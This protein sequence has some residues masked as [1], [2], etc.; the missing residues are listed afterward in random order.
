MTDSSPSRNTVFLSI[1]AVVGAWLLTTFW[2]WRGYIGVDDIVYAKYAFEFHRLPIN[3]W[4]FRMPTIMAI[5]ASFALLG[6]TEFAAALPTVLASLGLSAGVALVCGWPR[7][8]NWKTNGAMLLVATMPLDSDMR[9]IPGASYLTGAF[10]GLGTAL[11]LQQSPAMR[12][13]GGLILAIC[14]IGYEV[15]VFY[16]GILCLAALLLDWRRNWKPVFGC[17][18]LCG[19]FQVGEMVTYWKLLG[20]P[21]A[22]FHTAVNNPGSRIFAFDPDTG[23]QGVRYFTWPLEI[24]VVSKAFGFCLSVALVGGYFLQKG[25]AMPLRILYWSCL[26]TWFWYGY[27]TLS[28]TSYMTLFR[29][30]H[31]YGVLCLAI[32]CLVPEVL[33]RLLPNRE[34]FSVQAFWPK[35]ALTG[36]IGFNLMLLLAG[37]SWGQ[38]F[39]TARES[40]RFAQS[41]PQK[42]F[43]TDVNT[44]NI[45]FVAN[46]FR[47][48][49]NVVCLNGPSVQTHLRQNKELPNVPR[50][51][52]PEV[53]ADGVIINRDMAKLREL[54][55]ELA[56]F[57]KEHPGTKSVIVAPEDKLVGPIL[58]RVGQEKLAV[59][60]LG[61][62]LITLR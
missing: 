52:F 6:P 39:D 32:C 11:F 14:F 33:G 26:A 8:I 16:V 50:Y 46:A 47:M 41:Q 5:R 10:S 59:L 36:L 57:L 29:Q 37:G 35:A 42:K 58:R 30:F 9:S 43:L 1:G 13:L 15:A 22:R 23:I 40:L 4:E 51:V 7:T 60:R 61:A 18:A 2:C 21:M 55:P 27:G 34:R 45:L 19:L 38:E 54:D 12:V 20:D 56:S 17:L 53:A 31:Y 24:L 28:P 44:M 48:P 62:E 25:L 49:A 3:W